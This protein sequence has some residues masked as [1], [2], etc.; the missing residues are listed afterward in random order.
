MTLISLYLWTILAGAIAG[1]SL[2]L[3]GTQLATRDRAMQTLCVGQGA[4]VGVLLGIA[5]LHDY[6]FSWLGTIGPFSSGLLLSALTF[7]IADKIVEGKSASKNTAFAFLFAFLLAT[8]YLI[9]S[10]FPALESHMAQVYFGDLATLTVQNSKVTVVAGTLSLVAFIFS[11]KRFSHLSFER[12]IFGESISG[13]RKFEKFFQ[14][15]SLL[16][17]C[18]S[19]QFVGFLFTIAM[20]FVPTALFTYTRTKGLR[21]H[22]VLCGTIAALSS[23]LGFLLSLEFTRLPTVPAIVAT[24]FVLGV[25]ILGIEKVIIFLKAFRKTKSGRSV[26]TPTAQLV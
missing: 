20:L 11:W 8:G 17:L 6:E 5:L 26:S 22:L 2:S 19:V 23:A 9:S 21:L 4:M 7:F 10:L 3:L 12:A 24:M 14:A 15:I 16:T 18:F 1:P 25:L 13:V